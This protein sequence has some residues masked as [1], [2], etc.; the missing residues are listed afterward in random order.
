VLAPTPKRQQRVNGN[1]MPR[2]TTALPPSD[3]ELAQR[4]QRGCPA[5]F[6][7]LVRRYQVPLM[8][9]LR[10]RA[11]SA[12]AG[13]AEDLV[14]DTFLRAY[15]HLHRY[16]PNWSF[17]TW[18]FTIGRRLSI[19]Q[20]RRSRPRT[21]WAALGAVADDRWP[22]AL[23]AAEEDSRR[24]LWDLAAGVLTEQQNTTL[25][26]YY[27][28]DMTVRQIAEVLGR[29]QMAV[30]TMLFRARKRLLPFLR[31]PG[32]SGHP[33]GQAKQPAA[34]PATSAW[35]AATEVNHG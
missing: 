9:F 27:V 11:G 32:P 23:L 22:P 1:N 28:E 12:D 2:E 26:L 35:R 6:E 3:E 5:S 13:G 10:Q 19:N 20:Q 33:S 31:E 14:Q 25:W 4:A 8:H 24:R 21:G 18:L 15:E 17:R 16:R 34:T 7:E 30:K 29:S